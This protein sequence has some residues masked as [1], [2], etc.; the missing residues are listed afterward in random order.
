MKNQLKNF[1]KQFKKTSVKPFTGINIESSALC[2]LKCWICPTQFYSGPATRGN[3]SMETFRKLLPFFKQVV[4]VDLTGW[5]EPLLNPN[6]FEMAILAKK[7][8]CP[9]VTLTTNGTLLNAENIERIISTEIDALSVSIDS[10]TKET[11][12][13]LKKGSD[14]SQV[15]SAIQEL[16]TRRNSSGSKRPYVSASFLLMRDNMEEI[17]RFTDLMAKLNVNDVAFKNLSAVFS[18]EVMS[19]VIYEGYYSVR[20]DCEGRDKYIAEAKQLAEKNGIKLIFH[21]NFFAE[22]INDCLIMPLDYPFIGWNGDVAPCCILGHPVTQLGKNGNG[23]AGGVLSFGNVN[24]E[25]LDRIWYKERYIELRRK[26]IAGKI[27]EECGDC[28]GLYS[29]SGSPLR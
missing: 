22:R 26:I 25:S 18:P 12:V 6:L 15:I 17:P 11:H 23:I 7:A 2:N 16:I 24:E 19:Q 21:G 4:N 13:K 10:A 8:G 29:V 5:G 14:F 28:L 9:S 27:P 3:M 1:I 20:A